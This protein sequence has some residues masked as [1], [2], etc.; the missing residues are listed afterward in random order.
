MSVRTRVYCL[1]CKLDSLILMYTGRYL[2]F[3]PWYTVHY[4][5]LQRVSFYSRTLSGMTNFS[6]NFCAASHDCQVAC[7]AFIAFEIYSVIYWNLLRYCLGKKWH[8]HDKL[9]HIYKVKWEHEQH[10][11]EQLPRDTGLEILQL[12]LIIFS[13]Y[14]S[15]RVD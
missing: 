8:S 13:V 15:N 14:S 6:L 10:L 2:P 7:H 4:F 3:I 11:L 12:L 9:P 1:S 5:D